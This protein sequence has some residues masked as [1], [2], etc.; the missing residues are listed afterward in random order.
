MKATPSG[1]GENFK[2]NAILF[3]GTVVL[4]WTLASLHM[5]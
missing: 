4:Y 2:D 5:R 3:L 1:F